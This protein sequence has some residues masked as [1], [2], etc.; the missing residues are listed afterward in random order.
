[1]SGCF[2]AGLFKSLGK[3]LHTGKTLLWILGK[4]NENHLF[5]TW[6]NARKLHTQGG[7]GGYLTSIGFLMLSVDTCPRSAF[8]PFPTFLFLVCFLLVQR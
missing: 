1:V 2:L 8:L 4:G 7:W 5:N 3:G 6:G